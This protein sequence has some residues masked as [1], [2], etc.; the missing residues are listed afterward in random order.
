MKKRILCTA[1]AGVLCLSSAVLAGCGGTVEIRYDNQI[2][3]DKSYNEN[4]F[5]RNDCKI[6]GADPMVLKITDRNSPEYGY[7]YQYS[8]NSFTVYRSKDLHNW[9]NVSK[10]VGH[11]AYILGANDFGA[12]LDGSFWA[13]EVVYDENDGKY[14]LFFSMEPRYGDANHSDETLMCAVSD[15][16]Y[17]PF[18]AVKEGVANPNRDH[19]LENYF[20]D[21]PVLTAQLREKYPQRFAED[22]TYAAALDPSPFTD[23]A[24]GKKY[25]YWTSE[26]YDAIE[27]ETCVFGMEMENWTTPKYET[28]TML[29]RP[30]YTTVDGNEICDAEIATNTINEGAFMYAKPNGNGGYTY[31][32]TLSVNN[33]NNKTYSAIQAIGSSPLGTFTKLQKADGGVLLGTDNQLWDHLSGP[34]H[35]SFVEEDGKLYILYHQHIDVIA[36]GAARAL[37]L[38]E[39]KF[40]TNDKGQEVMYVNGPTRSIQLLPEFASEYKNIAGDAKITASNKEDAGML[41]DGLL[42]LYSYI[43]YVK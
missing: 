8:T 26:R 6:P 28:V 34:G 17:G 24:T 39:V 43:D 33:Y 19:A 4:L 30:R 38:D 23:P 40:V 42:S 16:P 15:Q 21:M 10:K 22:Y 18:V 3:E 27:S 36:A 2:K 20:F 41:T 32:L 11:P 1:L 12:A 29:T 5:Y 9:E 35:H 13:P 25:L 7:Y 31:Y 37:S 14:Y